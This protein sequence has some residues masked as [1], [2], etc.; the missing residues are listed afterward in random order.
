MPYQVLMK[1]AHYH[2]GI[3]LIT[4][5]IFNG[6]SNYFAI[7]LIFFIIYEIFIRYFCRN[8]F[9]RSDKFWIDE[10]SYIVSI[11]IYNHIYITLIPL[12]H[13]FEIKMGCLLSPLVSLNLRWG[14]IIDYL[15]GYFLIM[16][17]F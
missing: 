16:S 13:I 3:F 9:Q 4:Y 11:C 8:L 6:I 7:Y 14:C 1:S 15:G 10:V 2:I 12:L 17:I 5:Y